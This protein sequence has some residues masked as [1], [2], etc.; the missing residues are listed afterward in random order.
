MRVDSL[1]RIERLKGLK[2][3][4]MPVSNQGDLKIVFIP[5]RAGTLSALTPLFVSVS[6]TIPRPG[7][8]PGR[9]GSAP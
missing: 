3:C 4:T 1:D 6:A 7:S 9:P 5:L 8:R 2:V